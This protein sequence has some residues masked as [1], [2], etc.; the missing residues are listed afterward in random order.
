[1]SEPALSERRRPRD[2]GRAAS[3]GQ[4]GDELSTI[5]A[6]RE[7]TRIGIGYAGFHFTTDPRSVP[8]DR[9]VLEFAG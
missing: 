9:R 6:A 7:L 2:R 5:L 1:M 4:R 3:R 8:I